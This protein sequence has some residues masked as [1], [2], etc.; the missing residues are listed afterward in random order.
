MISWQLG[1]R[2]FFC[3]CLCDCIDQT[4][5][6]LLLLILVIQISNSG[7]ATTGWFFAW[8][9]LQPR[10]GSCRGART[11]STGWAEYS[12]VLA[13][14]HTCKYRVGRTGYFYFLLAWCTCQ[15]WRYRVYR[16]LA[17]L[18]QIYASCLLLYNDPQVWDTYGR[19]LYSSGAH[20]YPVTSVA[21]SNDGEL[22][23]VG[24]FNT[25]RLCDKIGW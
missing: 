8:T 14:L 7:T 25:L 5:C 10:G 12:F 4:K 17:F 19:Q 15:G 23:A 1:I 11:A 21:W 9:G 22:F 3:L 6:T 13:L 16:I 24:S 18:H 20:D 2:S